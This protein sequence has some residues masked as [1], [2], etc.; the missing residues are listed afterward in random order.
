[1][2]TST[3]TS[4]GRTPATGRQIG[5]PFK[6]VSPVEQREL[7]ITI[8]WVIKGL[9]RRGAVI[10]ISGLPGSRKSWL[11]LDA[12]VCVANGKDNFVGFEIQHGGPVLVFCADD[13]LRTAVRRLRIISSY[14]LGTDVYEHIALVGRGQ[15]HLQN[16]DAWLRLPNTIE[17]LASPEQ[18]NS[19]PALIVI[20]TAAMAG[21][22][23]S[24]FGHSYPEKLGW[25]KGVAEH[26]RCC[27]VLVEHMAKPKADSPDLDVR[28]SQWGGVQ[29]SGMSEGAWSLERH[30]D[31]VQLKTSD[32][33]AAE[34][35][36]LWLKFSEEEGLYSVEVT[37]RGD[38]MAAFELKE[39]R[40]FAAGKTA[41]TVLELSKGLGIPDKTARRRL[42]QLQ[43]NHEM[44]EIEPHRGQTPAKYALK[45]V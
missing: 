23:T 29:K 10:S 12:A 39:I 36:E 38:S 13:G 44:V 11:M 28:S 8:E 2:T 41:F 31:H 18:F 37:E 21:A 26:Y 7:D 17:V 24:D 22:P 9:M 5:D 19:A 42:Q 15:L 43:R 14:R 27:I 25:L 6:V 32:K 34:R 33:E 45:V 30:G 35:Y 3:I 4:N 1:V 16:R 20:D 40:D